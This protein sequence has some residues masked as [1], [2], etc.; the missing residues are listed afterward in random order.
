MGCGASKVTPQTGEGSKIAQSNGHANGSAVKSNGETAE[1]NTNAN[2]AVLNGN[3]N[4]KP[5]GNKDVVNSNREVFDKH[6]IEETRD[7]TTGK[8]IKLFSKLIKL[9][10]L[11]FI[12]LRF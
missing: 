6:A 5:Q 8:W 11:S 7:S 2:S 9:P 12:I 4:V 10:A 1:L 3:L